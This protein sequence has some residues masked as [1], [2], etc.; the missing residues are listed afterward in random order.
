MKITVFTS[1]QPRH[2]HLIESLARVADEVFAV[3]ECSTIAPGS[4]QDFYQKTPVMQ[5]Y[6]GHVLAAE[7]AVF[8]TPRMLTG[9][10]H[11]MAVRMGDLN[12]LSMEALE[13]ALDSDVY[14]VFGASFIKGPLC[15][16]LVDRGAYNIHMGVSPY[17][18][19]HSTNFWALYDNRAQY[20]GAT[21]H[22]LTQG[23][24]SGPILFHALPEIEAVEPFLLGM[25]SVKAAHRS[26]VAK[27]ADETLFSLEEFPQDKTM[28]LRYSKGVQF[29]DEIAREYLDRLASPDEIFEQL[30]ATQLSEFV[31]PTFG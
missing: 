16:F 25:K 27:I 6:F 8:G 10:I 20:V 31:S 17:Y 23:L 24:D 28:Q 15:K 7:R 26:L 4:V 12:L 30:N 21:I 3:Q 22:K 14:V 18:R 1:N 19:G 5:E 9:N 11:H 13:V 2:L 29:T